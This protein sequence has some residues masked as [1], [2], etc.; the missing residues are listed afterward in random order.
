LL[1]NG[2]KV[3]GDV[4]TVLLTTKWL[5][6]GIEPIAVLNEQD[7]FQQQFLPM[8]INTRISVY[9]NYEQVLNLE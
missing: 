2:A 3:I 5:R 6:A 7:P 9:Q 4:G 8:L 1:P